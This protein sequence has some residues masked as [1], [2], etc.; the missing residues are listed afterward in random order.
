[1]SAE[2]AMWD[3]MSYPLMAPLAYVG[4]RER[5][6]L[7]ASVQTLE[8]SLKESEEREQ[9]LRKLLYAI[10]HQEGT[11]VITEKTLVEFDHSAAIR[12]EGDARDNS[13]KV[14]ISR[15]G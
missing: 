15:S 11:I 12:T 8:A 14:W 4:D 7:A 6:M 1:M 5:K 10:L 3:L 9:S 2:D 13:I